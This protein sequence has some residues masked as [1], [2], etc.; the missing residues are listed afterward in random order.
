MGGKTGEL[1]GRGCS[2]I[3]WTGTICEG[4]CG[5]CD[6]KR[7]ENAEKD[8]EVRGETEGRIGLAPLRR[9]GYGRSEKAARAQE[10][11]EKAIEEEERSSS[12]RREL[13]TLRR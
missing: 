12:L 8:V 9:A 2:E 13:A 4:G 1:E 5:D 10:A 6:N 11:I 3:G 7:D